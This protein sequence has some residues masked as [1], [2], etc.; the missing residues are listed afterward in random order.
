MDAGTISAEARNAVAYAVSK[1]Y[2]KGDAANNFNPK[3]TL[4]RAQAATIL[5]RVLEDLRS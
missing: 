4:T 5:T 2:F 3:G 1:G